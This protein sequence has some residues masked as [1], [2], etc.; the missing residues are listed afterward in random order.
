MRQKAF[1]VSAQPKL[2]RCSKRLVT[3][4]RGLS[5]AYLRFGG[6]RTDFL[7][8]HN[9]K[10]LAK[11]RGPGPDYYLKNYEDDIVR[12]DIALDKQKGCKLASHPDMMLEL[13]REKA[14]Q[15]QQVLLKEQLSNHYSD[16]TIT[17]SGNLILDAMET[18]QVKSSQVKSTPLGEEEK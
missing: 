4:A 16:V 17:V 10:N 9:L 15:T 7:Q 3:L 13:Q 12:S 1:C 6:K 8:F 14:A 5:P 11:F 2:S 18:P